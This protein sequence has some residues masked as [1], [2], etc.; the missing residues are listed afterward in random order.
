MESTIRKLTEKEVDQVSGGDALNVIFTPHGPK[1]T[2]SELHVP[3]SN[4]GN[5]ADNF[6]IH[7][8]G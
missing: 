4:P 7:F 5:G 1:V 3:E 6:H 2:G 8:H